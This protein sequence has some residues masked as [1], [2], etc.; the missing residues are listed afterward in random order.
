MIEQFDCEQGSEDW[1]RLRLGLCTASNFDSI[2]ASGRDEGPSLTR[3]DLMYG[4]AGEIMTEEPMENYSNRTMERGKEME[5]EARKLYA[6][7]TGAKLDR[8]GFIKNTIGRGCVVGCSPDSLIGKNGVLEI[9][10]A[11]PK[12]FIPM[13]LKGVFPAEFRPQCQGSLLVTERE[14]V[15]LMVYYRRMPRPLIVRQ[16][17]DEAYIKNIS[18]AVEIFAHELKRLVEKLRQ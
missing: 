18:D 14:W 12:R 1:F 2:M 9:K 3:M 8:P 16:E 11:A 7:A 17:R 15:D 4:L 10:T 6:F 5:P 13:F